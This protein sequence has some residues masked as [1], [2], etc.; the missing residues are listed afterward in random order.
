M[1]LCAL[2]SEFLEFFQQKWHGTL[3]LSRIS[4][5][6]RSTSAIHFHDGLVVFE[7]RYKEPAVSME[8]GSLRLPKRFVG[9]SLYPSHLADSWLPHMFG[10]GSRGA[11]DG[12]CSIPQ[13]FQSLDIYDVSV[14]GLVMETLMDHLKSLS[15]RQEGGELKRKCS[16]LMSVF[17]D[18]LYFSQL[19]MDFTVVHLK[20][21]S[22]AVEWNTSYRTPLASFE[23]RDVKEL[24][25]WYFGR[26]S[27]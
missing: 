9:F 26:G 6:T 13:P 12:T 23:D 3:R 24:I 27:G 7:K 17:Q 15:L 25:S 14:R 21:R 4:A 20:R 2:S 5:L 8:T 19:G 18:G 16:D 22:F 10:M 11:L 1:P